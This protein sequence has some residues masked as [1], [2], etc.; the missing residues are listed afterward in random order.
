MAGYRESSQR[1]FK[2]GVAWLVLTF[3]LALHVLDEA[4]TGFLAVYNPT[5]LAVRA[6]YPWFPMPVF[7]FR[8]WLTGLICAVLILL[9]LA[10][11]FFRNMRW[12]RP[13]GYFAAFV[14][15][16][17]ALGH[18]TATILGRTVASVGFSRPAPGFYS[19][20]LLLIA[21]LYLFFV[22]VHSRPRAARMAAS[23]KS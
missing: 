7:T 16:L 22:L 1:D 13:L 10:P 21:S 23:G 8:V 5:V 15:I 2:L 19:S 14:N 3:A 4:L 17:N 18:I 20:P 11:L 6:R 9:A 12:I